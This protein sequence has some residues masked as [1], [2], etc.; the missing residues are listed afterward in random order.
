MRYL[1]LNAAVVFVQLSAVLGHPDAGDPLV[2]LSLRVDA[3]VP[4]VFWCL[5]LDLWML[6]GEAELGGGLVLLLPAG[7]VINLEVKSHS[8][9]SCYKV[10]IR[11]LIQFC[12]TCSCHWPNDKTITRY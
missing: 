4:D 12:W 3:E 9:I 6:D 8:V 11:C 2:Q 5:D 10:F 1:L 7:S